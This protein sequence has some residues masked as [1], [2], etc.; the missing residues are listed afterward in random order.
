VGIRGEPSDPA[1]TLG[2]PSLP[3]R[4]PTVGSATTSTLYVKWTDAEVGPHDAP[5][6]GYRVG[7][8]EAANAGRIDVTGGGVDEVDVGRAYD[9]SLQGLRSDTQYC[10][11]VRPY[12]EVGA[13]PVG[14][15][16]EPVWTLGRPTV[17][18][19]APTVTQRFADALAVKWSQPALGEHD[20]TITGYVIGYQALSDDGTAHDGGTGGGAPAAE[21]F[22]GY[23][24]HATVRGL[25]HDTMY[26]LY[27]R[28]VNEVGQGIAG[29]WRSGCRWAG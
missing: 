26:T 5:V 28:A 24:T 10:A 22:V 2:P 9:T 4:A 23:M 19:D 17:P 15:L 6:T 25:T 14:L 1:W 3:A 21:M 29:E 11:Y 12:N 7:V 27:V 8:C 20:A 13:G 16:A 18:P